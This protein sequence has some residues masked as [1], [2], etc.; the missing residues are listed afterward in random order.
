MTPGGYNKTKGIK[1]SY[2]ESG[3]EVHIAT[4]CIVNIENKNHL[5][6]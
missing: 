6:A 2:D 3:F 5:A 1:S 4:S